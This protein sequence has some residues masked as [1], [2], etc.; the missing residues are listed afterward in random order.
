MPGV[1][2]RLFWHGGL[3]LEADDAPILIHFDH[4]ELLG[5]LLHG[6]LDNSDGYIGSGVHMLIE[7]LGVIHL[8]DVIA[9]ENENEFR[10]FAADGINVLIYGVSGA[11][12]PLLR[13]AH[14]RRKN[15]D[16]IAEAGKRRPAGTNV[17]VQAER[18]VL[19]ED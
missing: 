19:S 8:V 13:D 4:P 7:H 17:A 6:N 1:V 16:V 12:V 5:G 2:R 11:L 18:L 9:G 14:L 3:F 15:F 10:S